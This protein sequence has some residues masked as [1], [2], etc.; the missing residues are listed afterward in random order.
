MQHT[1]KASIKHD[2]RARVFALAHSLTGRLSQ[3]ELISAITQKQTGMY[4]QDTS[5]AAGYPS[6]ALLCYY[7]ALCTQEEQAREIAYTY[8]QKAV[9]ATQAQPLQEAG[10]AKGTSGLTS[11]LAFFEQEGEQIRQASANVARQLARQALHTNWIKNVCGREVLDYDTVRGVSGVLRTLLIQQNPDA[12]VASTIVQLL[13]ILVAF[14]S[15]PD[16]WLIHS[17]FFPV[18]ASRYPGQ[19]VVNCGLAHGL[20]GPLAVLSLASLSGYSID[21]QNA[22][23]QRL[24]SWL[25]D[26]SLQTTWGIDW[27]DVI[28]AHTALEQVRQLPPARSGWCYGAPGVVRSLWLAGQALENDH[29]QTLAVQGMRAIL[30]RPLTTRRIDPLTL[31][32]GEAGLLLVALRF[33]QDTAD[34]LI[35]EHI[36]GFVH[37]ILQQFQP[38]APFGFRYD[39]RVGSLIDSLGFFTGAVGTLLALLAASS[40]VEPNWDRALLLS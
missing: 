35:E 39:F 13:Q 11:V 40:S 31:C 14:A 4:W 5:L 38:D 18:S 21:G 25:A 1:W 36:P 32:H 26:R 3:E 22:S 37:R 20:P 12:D 10:L 29:F 9:K 16:A 23:I 30:Q 2:L 6:L 19:F 33:L 34:P 17:S 28:P 15:D 7:T 24:A 27:P 8:L